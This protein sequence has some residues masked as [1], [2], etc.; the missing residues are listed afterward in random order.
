MSKRHSEANRRRWANVPPQ[1]RSQIMKLT[2][3]SKYAK[4]SDEDR[5]EIGR[6]LTE[7]R[8]AAKKH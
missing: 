8:N 1:A 2:A 4:M 7:S 5:L 6:R 3:K